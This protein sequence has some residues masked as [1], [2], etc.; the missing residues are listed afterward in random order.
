[1]KSDPLPL[2][3]DNCQNLVGIRSRCSLFSNWQQYNM[4]IFPEEIFLLTVPLR[5]QV[6]KVV[7]K[8]IKGYRNFNFQVVKSNFKYNQVLLEI[9]LRF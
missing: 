3:F 6:T 1:M 7:T 2:Y 8:K 5:M 4:A 9:K